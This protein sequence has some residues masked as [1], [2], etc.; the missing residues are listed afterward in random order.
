MEEK[1]VNCVHK[2]ILNVALT[3]LCFF[4]I[5]CCCYQN[6]ASLR[7]EEYFILCYQIYMLN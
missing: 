5:Q 2:I 7:L 6:I 4:K 3:G 1:L